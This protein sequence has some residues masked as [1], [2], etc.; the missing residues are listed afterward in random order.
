VGIVGGRG[1]VG[2][3]LLQQLYRHP[4]FEVACVASAAMA[5]A[6]IAESVPE[7]PD[8]DLRF[9][10]PSPESLQGVQ[11]DA[12]ILAL[13]NGEAARLAPELSR[14]AGGPKLIDIS[15][16]FR[17]DDSWQYGLADVWAD[18]IRGT[19]RVANPGCYATG[20]QLALW[21]VRRWLRDNAVAFGVSGFSGAGRT[22]SPRN[23]PQRLADNLLPYQLTGHS[24]EREIARHL[25]QPVRLLP[26]VAAFFRGISLTIR[27]ELDERFS[28]A[29]L[30]ACYQE[31][32][33]STPTVAV[34]EAIPEIADVRQT[35]ECRIGG[36]AADP[37][38]ENRWIVVSVLDN[39]S[40]GA[41]TQAIQNLNLMFGYDGELGL[42]HG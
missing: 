26:H 2:Q 30:L 4:R 35:P 6:R 3:E 8:P 32:Y 31:Q 19:P 15:A 20:V 24:H 38:G 21:P 39:L 25:G 17:C 34:T 41:A 11:A 33:R 27:F 7:L 29:D 5:G 12:W 9:V 1:Y 16:D 23:D 18:S 13:A 28:P 42:A 37:S 22:P 40:K 14:G 10:S 36:L